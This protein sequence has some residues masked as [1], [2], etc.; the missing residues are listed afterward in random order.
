MV[1]ICLHSVKVR[2]HLGDLDGVQGTKGVAS[3]ASGLVVLEDLPELLGLGVRSVALLNGT[4]LGDNGLGGVGA[5]D[6]LEAGRGPPL[7]DLLNLLTELL[8]FLIERHVFFY[9]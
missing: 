6:K 1:L 2:S 9:E 7:L 3:V 4:A 5:L 8:L